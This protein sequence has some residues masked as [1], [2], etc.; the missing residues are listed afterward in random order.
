MARLFEY[1][2]KDLLKY[3]GIKVP[4]GKVAASPAEVGAVARTLGRPVVLKAQA[5]VTGRAGVGGIHFAG[6]PEEAEGASARIFGMELKGFAVDKVLVEEKLSIQR[7]FF[8]SFLIDDL[9]RRPVMIFSDIGGSGVEELSRAHPDRIARFSARP[10]RGVREHEARNLLRRLGITGSLQMKLA[11]T[12]KDLYRVMRRYEARSL[13]INPLVLT[14]SGEI[15]AADCRITVDD[16]AV[17]RHPEL[18]IEVAREF[19]RPATELEKIAY[20]VEENDYRGTFY[21]LQM[22]T[23]PEGPG[24]IG[25]HGA[26]GGGSMLAMDA[27]LRQGFK[28]PNFCDTSGNPPGSKVY[29]A[30]RIILS[31]KNLEGY[32]YSGSG[33]ASQ[34]QYHTARGLAKAFREVRLPFPAVIRVGGNAEEEAMRLLVLYTKDLPGKVEVYGRDTSADYCALR[35]RELIEEARAERSEPAHV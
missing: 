34:E 15:Y 14:E 20:K 18:G 12:L 22:E 21:F 35:L 29:R 6:S 25:F 31:Q 17:H 8:V 3:N 9:S 7:E 11:R 26:G 28:I 19:D 30:A 24:Y 13:E 23:N 5:W 4:E 2:G 32:F 16:N 1:Q 27:L 33:V 10:S